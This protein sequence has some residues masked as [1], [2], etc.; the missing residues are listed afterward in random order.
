MHLSDPFTT[1]PHSARELSGPS[2]LAVKPWCSGLWCGFQSL[3]P[4]PALESEHG[5]QQQ[6]ALAGLLGFLEGT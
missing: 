4:S 5:R 3:L 6:N 2:A 1:P